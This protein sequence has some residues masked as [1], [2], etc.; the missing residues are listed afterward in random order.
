MEHRFIETGHRLDAT[1]LPSFPSLLNVVV[2]GVERVHV[3]VQKGV[4]YAANRTGS[5]VNKLRP[6]EVAGRAVFVGSPSPHS[7]LNRR[8][9]KLHRENNR[10][11]EVVDDSAVAR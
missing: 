7:G 9:N 6:N 10:Q 5:R 1:E 3:G 2:C 11:T 8:F 4:R